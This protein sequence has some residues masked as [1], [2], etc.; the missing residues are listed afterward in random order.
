MDNLVSAD[1]VTADGE[2]LICDAD[3]DAELFWA[4]RG[5]GENF[6]VL[7]SLEFRL[8]SVVEVLGG[9]TFYPLEGEVIRGYR[10]LIDDAPE[11]LGAILGITLAP[12]LPFVA[13][14]WHGR[15]AYDAALRPFSQEGGYVNF[16]AEVSAAAD[17][18]PV[19]PVRVP[20][21]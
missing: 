19:G 15:P 2:F 20:F 16:M 18:G 3:H 9:P 10:R 12:L 5:G 4:L 17:I 1:V 21:R 14:H 6:G 13:E 11:E 8:Y 7:T